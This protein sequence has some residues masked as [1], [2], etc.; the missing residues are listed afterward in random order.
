[1]PTDSKA[2]RDLQLGMPY[3]TACNRLARLVLFD[4]AKRCGM[5]NC[6]RCGSPID[7]VAEFSIDHKRA[8]R[9][10]SAEL[11]W[12]IS[13]IAFAHG[14]CNKRAGSKPT[15]WLPGRKN[16]LPPERRR[17]IARQAGLAA[18]AKRRARQQS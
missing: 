11:F 1:M 14:S 18:Q 3:G 17:E 2:G 15:K 9:Y 16:S 13:N 4:L 12:D 6:Y 7:S 5:G 10:V 8:W